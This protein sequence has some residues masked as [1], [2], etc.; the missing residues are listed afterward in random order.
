MVI[1]MSFLPGRGWKLLSAK[2]VL[3]FRFGYVAHPLAKLERKRTRKMRQFGVDATLGPNENI[4]LSG[5]QVTKDPVGK[6]VWPLSGKEGPGS[7]QRVLSGRFCCRPPRAVSQDLLYLQYYRQE[8]FP[9]PFRCCSFL[10]CIPEKGGEG[11]VN[12]FQCTSAQ[13]QLLFTSFKAAF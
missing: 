8:V 1:W 4:F 3:F 10:I 11:S 6:V 2:M 5:G 9:M 12:A 13:S 7:C